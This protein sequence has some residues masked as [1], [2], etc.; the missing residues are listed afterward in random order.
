MLRRDEQTHDPA[1]DRMHGIIMQHKYRADQDGS[2]AVRRAETP[3]TRLTLHGQD[4]ELRPMRLPLALATL[5][6]SVSFFLQTPV[7]FGQD[8]GSGA[9]L[10]RKQEE[11]DQLK[12]D[13]DKAQEDLKKLQRENERLRRLLGYVESQS[14]RTVAARVIAED[15]SSWFRTVEIDRGYEDGVIDGLPVIDAAASPARNTVSAPSSSTPANRLLGC[16][17]SSTSRMT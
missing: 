5:A 10:K 9:E 14:S 12:R 11:V 4:S 1:G 7:A 13:L 3:Q 8:S 15:A 17:A 6:V 16:C 2:P